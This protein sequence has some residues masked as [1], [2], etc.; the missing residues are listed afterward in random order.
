[1]LEKVRRAAELCFTCSLVW[2]GGGG[3]T[4]ECLCFVQAPRRQQERDLVLVVVGK[5]F[6][7][8]CDGSDLQ[9]HSCECVC[10]L[11]QLPELPAGPPLSDRTAA[12]GKVLFQALAV[13]GGG[14]A[15][16]GKLH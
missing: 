2:R 12:A 4:F 3:H 6:P 7:R 1:M 9:R 14:T 15:R 10:C 11:S 8:E 16:E 13:G 5:A